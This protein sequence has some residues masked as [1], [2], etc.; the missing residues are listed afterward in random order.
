MRLHLVLALLA[1]GCAIDT[2][3]VGDEDKPVESENVA[4]RGCGTEVGCNAGNGGGVY[5]EEN[6]S[7]GIGPS[8]FMIAH[9]I[10]NGSNVTFVGRYLQYPTE[11]L[12]AFGT[13][14][15]V[16]A[17][18]QN[19]T[20]YVQAIGENPIGQPAY[21]TVPWIKF[22]NV[23]TPITGTQIEGVIF[24]IQLDND[25]AHYDLSWNDYHLATTA[26][27]NGPTNQNNTVH[28]FNMRWREVRFAAL[29]LPMVWTDYCRDADGT[30]DHIVFQQ[31]IGV[32]PVSGDLAYNQTFTTVG[33]VHGAIATVRLWGYTYRENTASADLFKAAIHMKRASYCGD[34]S[35]YTVG[36]TFIGISDN[37][38]I[39]SYDPSL[40]IEAQWGPNGATCVNLDAVRHSDVAFAYPGE[41][42]AYFGGTCPD[43]IDPLPDCDGMENP[44]LTSTASS[45]H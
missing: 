6:G 14:T 15:V 17:T 27:V 13:G 8:H 36:G 22:A 39:N 28:S 16:S 21:S 5:T 20:Y 29:S 4:R 3:D 31:G 11:P 25:P 33:C 12:W 10:N 32:H 26:E 23:A 24:H 18:Y 9:F 42:P 43:R 2:A 30:R 44:L 38:G 34:A 35:F 37:Q 45:Q 7:A 19:L 40:R 1:S 41:L